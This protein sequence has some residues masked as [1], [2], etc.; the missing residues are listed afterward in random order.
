MTDFAIDSSTTYGTD[1]RW[2]TSKHGQAEARP[3]TLDV[4]KFIAGT[5][6]NIGTRRD[7]V[8]PSG[9]ALVFNTGTKLYEPWDPAVPAAKIAGYINDDAGVETYRRVGVAQSTTSTFALLVHGHIE[10]A[11]LPVAAQR[12]GA[13]AAPTTGLFIYV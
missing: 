2:R 1:V 10:A 11:R 9:V 7:G 6:Y 4:T 5:H 8:I 12:A 3:G 13:A